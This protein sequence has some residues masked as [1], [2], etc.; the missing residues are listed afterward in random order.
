MDT[1]LDELKCEYDSECSLLITTPE[2][3]R[4]MN[5]ENRNIDSETDVLSFPMIEFGHPCNY[6]CL[7]EDD[8]SQFDPESGRLMLGDIVINYDRVI[9]QANEYGHSVKRELSFLIVHSI[10]HLFG[11]DHMTDADR[12]VMEDK[13]RRI[14]D[15]LGITR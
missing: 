15:T 3:I 8:Y 5:R 12:L 2:S 6:E 13:Q 14:L 9:S 1:A 11:Y 4:I 10:L 7:D